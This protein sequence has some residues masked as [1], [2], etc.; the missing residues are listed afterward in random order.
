MPLIRCRTS[1]LI[2]LLLL[3]LPATVQ[4]Y[5]APRCSSEV[6]AVLDRLNIPQSRIR[7]VSVMNI[8]GA[9]GYGGGHVERVEGWVSFT[10]CR[11]NLVVSLDN[12][13]Q[14][15]DVYTTYQCRVPGVTHY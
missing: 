15:K 9:T 11:G 5:S 8:Y 13:C 10:D 3:L 6:G 2:A 7:D 1:S 14:F 4:A 12:R